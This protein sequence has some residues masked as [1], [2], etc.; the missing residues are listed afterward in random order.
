VARLYSNE[1]F[2]LPVVQEL[3]TFGH[4]VVTIQERAK[5]NEAVADQD[6]LSLAILED[7]AVLTLNRKDFIRLHSLRPDHCGII[8]CTI[9]ADFPGQ[10]RRIH[11]AI[12]ATPDLHGQLVRVNRP[13]S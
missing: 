3:R 1:N 5:A 7:R 11:S 8:V 6:V 10:A 2:P 12:A 9:D 4:D 13:S